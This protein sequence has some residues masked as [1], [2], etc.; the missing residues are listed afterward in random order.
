MS[1]HCIKSSTVSLSPISPSLPSAIASMSSQL[2]FRVDVIGRK[3][4]DF[5][6]AVCELSCA[7][8]LLVRHY[9]GGI[10][11]CDRRGIR[12]LFILVEFD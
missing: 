9:M 10:A 8:Y 11:E 1:D 7:V 5:S 6:I 4:A 12:A 2:D 3:I